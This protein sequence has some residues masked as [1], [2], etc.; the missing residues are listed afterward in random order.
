MIRDYLRL[1]VELGDAFGQFVLGN[2]NQRAVQGA[3]R[4]PKHVRRMEAGMCFSNCAHASRDH[5]LLY[6]EGMAASLDLCV[7]IHHAWLL[8]PDG[9]ALDPTWGAKCQS[10][11]AYV[12]VAFRPS[13]LWPILA[14]LGTFGLLW[15]R[16]PRSIAQEDHLARLARAC[17]P[18][19]QL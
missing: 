15:N 1:T 4:M 3:A 11:S 17:E 9:R 10:L 7:P 16:L 18:A 5:G 12:G 8:G 19:R 6:V 2:A 14:G 13:K